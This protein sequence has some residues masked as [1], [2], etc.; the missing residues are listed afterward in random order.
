MEKTVK[1][2][3]FDRGLREAREGQY[4]WRVDSERAASMSAQ[5]A[6]WRDSLLEEAYQLSGC[7]CLLSWPFG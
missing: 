7:I 6:D 1:I 4:S 3:V 5:A 2:F